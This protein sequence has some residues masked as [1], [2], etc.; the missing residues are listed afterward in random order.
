MAHL[1][2]NSLDSTDTATVQPMRAEVLTGAASAIDQALEPIDAFHQTI[3]F[4]RQIA[5]SITGTSGRADAPSSRFDIVPGS[6]QVAED[7]AAVKVVAQLGS[8]FIGKAANCVR[9][10]LDAAKVLRLAGRQRSA[11]KST[12]NPNS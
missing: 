10:L 5:N 6:V 4:A 9:L 7:T 2:Q 1:S 8:Q 12:H 3:D 11:E